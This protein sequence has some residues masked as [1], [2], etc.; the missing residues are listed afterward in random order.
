MKKLLFAAIAGLVLLSTAAQATTVKASN[1]S[2]GTWVLYETKLS[3]GGIVTM[4]NRYSLE[5]FSTG[6]SCNAIANIDLVAV[7]I[8]DSWAISEPQCVQLPLLTNTQISSGAFPSPWLLKT[9]LIQ[10]GPPAVL[11]ACMADCLQFA[12]KA[13]CVVALD[14]LASYFDAYSGIVAKCE[15]EV[16]LIS[17]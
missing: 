14:F 16:D 10:D 2:P 8:G 13:N 15:Q 12:T 1:G 17:D 7:S 4:P 3:S 11:I 9:T 5:K 6:G